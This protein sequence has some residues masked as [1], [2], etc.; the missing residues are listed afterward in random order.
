M[1]TESLATP[2]KM[3]HVLADVI[4]HGG[5][6]QSVS[7]IELPLAT[8]GP[9][10]S[11][12]SEGAQV[13]VVLGNDDT[14]WTDPLAHVQPARLYTKKSPAFDGIG[15]VYLG[16][17]IS[18]VMGHL[19]A[20]WLERPEREQEERTDLLVE[21]MDVEPDEVIAD[22]GSGTGYFSLRLARQVPKG[23]VIAVDIQP[24]MNE[25]LEENARQEGIEN[26][27]TVLGEIDDT[28][29]PANTID[30]VLFV[31]AYHEFSHPWEMKR[32]LMKAMR[33]GG[34]IVLVEYRA[35]DPTVR[36][37][38]RHKMTEAQARREFEAAG[39]QWVRT[40]DDLPQQHVLIF[41]KPD[42]QT[43]GD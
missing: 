15:K 34:R 38:P 42:P 4:A 18:E 20:G 29:I 9:F 26:V 39:F 35:E 41:R 32:S 17:E 21:L 24:E 1:S 5:R 6:V 11:V 30:V 36:I 28:K 7:K 14:P 25:I 19:G 31:D 33:P 3:S 16:R 40:F 12:V 8:T 22:I 43:A 13:T 37:K 23:K 10:I 27:E 2:D